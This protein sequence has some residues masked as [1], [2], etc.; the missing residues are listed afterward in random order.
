MNIL[1]FGTNEPTRSVI[2]SE[3][4]HILAFLSNDMRRCKE[5]YRGYRVIHPINA[6]QFSYDAIVLADDMRELSG[7]Y[8]FLEK[9]EQ[10]ILYGIDP[11]KLYGFWGNEIMLVQVLRD[12]LKLNTKYSYEHIFEVVHPKSILN[13]H[14]DY[15]MERCESRKLFV[16]GVGYE[17]ISLTKMLKHMD[18]SV[19]KYISDS[20]A[21]TNINGVEVIDT[22]DLVYEEVGTF[23]VLVADESENYGITRNK[24]LNLGFLEDVDFTY[25]SEIP[26]TDE[27]FYFDVTLSYSR[28][29]DSMEGFE[30]YGDCNNPNAI[31]IVAL[32]G[33]TTESQLFYVKGW[34]PFLAEYLCELGIPAKIYC[35]GV[36]GYTSTQEL[37]KFQRDVLSLCPDI[38]ISYS[39]VNDLYMYPTEIENERCNRPFITQFQIDFI[40]QVLD[41]IKQT[42][43]G[44]PSPDI[45]DWEE[46]G[47]QTVFYGLKNNKSAARYWIDNMRMIKAL[48]NEFDIAFYSFF[49]PFRFNGYYERTP[50]QDVIHLRRDPLCVPEM[51]GQ[52][53]YSKKKEVEEIR[54]LIPLY[55]YI[56]DLSELFWHESEVYYDSVHVYE[57]GNQIIAHR[58]GHSIVDYLRLGKIGNGELKN[59]RL[60]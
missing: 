52:K 30:I 41:K 32:G 31:S 46:G 4:Y 28:I 16:Y 59:G 56:I 39:G 12:K 48:A 33:S 23:F 26:G 60:V 1:V 29:R 18:I 35:G 37:L 54:K 55:D 5:G 36:S 19:D 50:I 44:L 15:V 40:Q 3:K 7:I 53:F 24:L 45:P 9:T 17:A 38:V 21:G 47:Q 58:I 51:K 49:Q 6:E 8:S 27:P 20:K 43:Y 34:V 11:N 22:I 14:K 57:K 10:L 25:H 2:E 13:T 42:Q